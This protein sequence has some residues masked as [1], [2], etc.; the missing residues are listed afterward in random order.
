MIDLEREQLRKTY[1]VSRMGFAILSAAL[2]LACLTALMPIMRNFYPE[3]HRRI[4]TMPWFQ[5]L[6]VPITWGSLLGVTLLWGRF[7]HPGWQRRVGLLLV[8][9][10]VD[11]GL[12]FLEHGAALGL[13]QGDLGHDWL[14]QNVGQALGWAEFALIAGLSCEYLEHL[15]VEYARESG[16]TTRSMAATGAV[17]WL[18][19]FCQCTNWSGWPLVPHRIRSIEE[20]LLY[21]GLPPDLG[22]HGDAGDV[23]GPLRRADV[24]ARAGRDAVRGRGQ[25]PLEAAVGM[26]QGAGRPRRLTA[27][28]SRSLDVRAPDP[29]TTF[30]PAATPGATSAGGSGRSPRGSSP[31]E[32]SRRNCSGGS[33]CIPARPLRAR[34]HRR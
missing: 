22:D 34:W 24:G 7:D 18:L 19:L 11:A 33:R 4:I 17:V 12:W 15:G 25:R 10:L 31:R 20:F 3:L 1:E 23:P 8:M 26:D 27:S 21:P 28:V 5:W 9:S 6:D 30:P 29:V 14:R 2:V 16:K 32:W 13:V